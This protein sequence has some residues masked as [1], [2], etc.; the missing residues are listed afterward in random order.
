MNNLILKILKFIS[1]PILLSLI[2][3]ILLSNKNINGS[4]LAELYKFKTNILEQQKDKQK[5][6]IIGGSNAK[7]CYYSPILKKHFPEYEIVNA[8][9]QGNV[10]LLHSLNYLKPYLNKGDII[11]LSP[12]YGMLQTETGLF[13]NYELV[14]LM[15][16][17]DGVLKGIFT[18]YK[19]LRS[20]LA[21]SFFHY[22]AFGEILLIKHVLASK[23]EI[24]RVIK[25]FHNEYGDIINADGE[26]AYFSYD[27][28]IDTN[29]TKDAIDYL[30]NFNEYCIEN[31]VKLTINFP[32]TARQSVIKQVDDSLF[33]QS[34]NNHFKNIPT[35]NV[36][37]AAI[38]DKSHF[39]DSPYHLKTSWQYQHTKEL[40]KDLEQS[41]IFSK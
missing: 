10:G 8:G 18:D 36:P 11:I 24:D 12:E 38:T 17:Y 32:A 7:F 31:N 37:S 28:Q 22:R 27:I 39:Y 40:C 34:F 9:L 2:L 14:Q 25:E 30:N 19:Q 33:I 5:I 35:L 41:M 6:I 20:F 26:R 15:S 4:Y 1:I 21:Q 16:V 3:Y 23:E 13:G 29:F